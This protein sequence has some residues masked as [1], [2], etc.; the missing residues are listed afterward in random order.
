M[1]RIFR[2]RTLFSK[3]F[4][5]LLVSGIAIQVSVAFGLIAFLAPRPDIEKRMQA[6]ANLYASLLADNMAKS[7]TREYALKL[8]KDTDIDAGVEGATGWRTSPGAGVPTR[9]LA[10]PPT[11]V[12]FRIVDGRPLFERERTGPNGELHF[13]F[14]GPEGPPLMR[15][16]WIITFA[17]LI[18]AAVFMFASASTYRVLRP[19]SALDLAFQAVKDGDLSAN[20]PVSSHDELGRLTSAFNEMAEKIRFLLRDKEQMLL[21]ISHEFRAPL[22]R[23]SAASSLVDDSELYE[24]IQKEVKELDELIHTLVTASK[25]A[26]KRADSELEKV[27]L[28]TLIRETTS[29]FPDSDRRIRLD[30]GAGLVCSGHRRSLQYLVKNLVENA[31]KYSPTESSVKIGCRQDRNEIVLMVEDHGQ[32]ISKDELKKVFEPFFRGEA[33]REGNHSGFGLGLGLCK[34][35]IQAH[36][37]TLELFSDGPGTGVRAVVR[38]PS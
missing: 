14:L 22:A 9:S 4:L 7:P 24:A 34:R 13:F 35:I 1:K 10:S 30:L 15:T 16:E 37:G 12:P 19:I 11:D 3:L 8:L 32:G 2:P 25:M 21:E 18:V 29:R 26:S 38:L 20:L 36:G 5:I 33:A 28:E 23:V 31:L 27:D 6:N 17:I